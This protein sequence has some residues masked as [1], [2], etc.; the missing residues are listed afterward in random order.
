M[1]I[2]YRPN[3]NVNKFLLGLFLAA[4]MTTSEYDMLEKAGSCF[5]YCC[6]VTTSANSHKRQY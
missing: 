6:I 4:D 1:D 2:E 5:Y 3:I